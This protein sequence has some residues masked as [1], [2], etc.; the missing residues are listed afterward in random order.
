MLG[1]L[2]RVLGALFS[3]LLLVACCRA[4]VL[5]LSSGERLAGKLLSQEGGLIEFDSEKYGRLRLPSSVARLEVAP[6]SAPGARE[7]SAP[8]E[9]PKPTQATAGGKET[10]GGAA[11]IWTMR[12]AFDLKSIRTGNN[13]DSLFVDT[14]VTGKWTRDELIA[15]LKYDFE[16]TEGVTTKDR[17]DTGFEWNHAIDRRFFTT[18]NPQYERY[19]LYSTYGDYPIH[20]ITT[21]TGVGYYLYNGERGKLSIMGGGGHMMLRVPKLDFSYNSFFPGARLKASLSLW[22]KLKLEESLDY[23]R[24]TAFGNTT[25]VFKSQLSL[26]RPISKTLSFSLQHDY[27]HSDQ[28]SRQDNTDELRL[29]LIYER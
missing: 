28:E 27:Q 4:E 19:V 7:P 24:L 15:S 25:N 3:W 16:R 17:F 23:Y 18:L 5:V 21:L 22:G 9:S 8:S 13:R 1:L 26:I 20:T 11:K 6:Q 2:G 10:P 14:K 12:V 29:L